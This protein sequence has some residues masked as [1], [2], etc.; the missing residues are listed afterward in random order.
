MGLAGWRSLYIVACYWNSIMQIIYVTL[1]NNPSVE[2]LA[3]IAWCTLD[4][5]RFTTCVKFLVSPNHSAPFLQRT[6]LTYIK[7]QA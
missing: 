3:L 5:L 4:M 1:S 7:S 2:Q 6:R